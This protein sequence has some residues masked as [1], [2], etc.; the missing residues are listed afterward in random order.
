MPTPPSRDVLVLA[1]HPGD[2]TLGC[3]GT[4][5][6]LTRH[7][8]PVDVLFLSWGEILPEDAGT[9]QGAVTADQAGQRRREA[10]AA[11]QLLGVHEVHALDGIGGHLNEQPDL[12]LRLAQFFTQFGYQRLLCP[13]L[14]EKHPDH[15]AAVRGI[16]SALA[17]AP[18]VQ[19]I[20]FYEVWTPLVPNLVLPIDRTIEDKLAAIDQY[21][22][23]L[24]AGKYRQ[25]FSGLA[26]YRALLCIPA[27]RAE[28]FATADAADLVRR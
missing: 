13:S 19:D 2:E 9:Y 10:L 7:G 20:W 11:C 27:R 25:A 14:E 28:A 6:H 3:G 17:A 21:Q 5:R 15:A 26:A 12:T 4:I 1:T 23:L 24:A 16:R 8:T 18:R 22:S